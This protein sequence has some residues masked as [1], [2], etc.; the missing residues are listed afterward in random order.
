MRTTCLPV[1]GKAT[2][3]WTQDSLSLTTTAG[4]V[5]VWRSRDGL[6]VFIAFDGAVIEVPTYAA[7]WI[8]NSLYSVAGPV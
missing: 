5:D 4:Q 3:P 6:T 8:S 7:R 2:S 1:A